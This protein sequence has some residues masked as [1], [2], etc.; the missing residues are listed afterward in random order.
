MLW[1]QFQPYEPVYCFFTAAA[2]RWSMQMRLTFL[3]QKE[4]CRYVPVDEKSELMKN[5]I[6]GRKIF[7]CKRSNFGMQL[8]G[9]E[10]FS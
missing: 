1:Q 5:N 7:S 10:T 4:H 9:G 2:L 3:I 6:D 8:E